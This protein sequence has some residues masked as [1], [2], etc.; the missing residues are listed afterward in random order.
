MVCR[1]GGSQPAHLAWSDADTTTGNPGQP[2]GTI[3]FRGAQENGAQAAPGWKKRKGAL[4][5]GPSPI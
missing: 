1:V 4:L 2:A 3:H 5:P